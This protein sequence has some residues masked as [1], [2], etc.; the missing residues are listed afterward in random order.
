[1]YIDNIAQFLVQSEQFGTNSTLYPAL[2]MFD[3]RSPNLEKIDG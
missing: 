2:R 3:S 1:M